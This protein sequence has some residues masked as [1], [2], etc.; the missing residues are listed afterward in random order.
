MREIR[1]FIVVRQMISLAKIIINFFRPET[2]KDV[3]VKSDMTMVNGGMDTGPLGNG[4]Q[5]NI[6]LFVK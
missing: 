6:M 3:F 5:Y 2:R 4:F 1:G